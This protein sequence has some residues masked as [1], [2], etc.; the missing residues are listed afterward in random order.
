MGASPLGTQ[1]EGRNGAEEGQL[2]QQCNDG[3][4][5][6]IWF[7]EAI[8]WSLWRSGREHR[9]LWLQGGAMGTDIDQIPTMCI[10]LRLFP[11][12][13]YKLLEAVWTPSTLLLKMSGGVR[14]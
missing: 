9:R 4:I 14:I 8:H 7:P 11:Q 12:Q 5:S 1:G 6:R 13:P 10:D 3:G 2:F